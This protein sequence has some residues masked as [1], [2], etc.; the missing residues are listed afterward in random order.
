[1]AEYFLRYSAISRDMQ[2][3]G[4]STSEV[5]NLSCICDNFLENTSFL[6][7]SWK[8]PLIKTIW[9]LYP[10]DVLSCSCYIS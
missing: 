4:F 1:M 8:I 6:F 3:V 7:F 9:I 2:I 10:V 5:V